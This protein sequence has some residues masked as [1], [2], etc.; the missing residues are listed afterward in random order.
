MNQCAVDGTRRIDPS[1]I[2][3]LSMLASCQRFVRVVS[4][5]HWIQITEARAII[6]SEESWPPYDAGEAV[7]LYP[8]DVP[9][10][11]L[12]SRAE[13]ICESGW[14][15]AHIL[16]IEIPRSLCH[17]LQ[18]DRSFWRYDKASAFLGTIAEKDGCS[19]ARIETIPCSDR[20]GA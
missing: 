16:S 8:P 1:L 13:E 7:F 20:F 2:T 5:K 11:F 17:R 4:D 10:R 18:R 12:L 19:I 3:G 9:R 6:P 15:P 14:G